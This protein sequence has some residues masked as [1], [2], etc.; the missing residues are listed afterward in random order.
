MS[1]T[2]ESTCMKP[3]EWAAL[4]CLLSLTACGIDSGN[5]T[6]PSIPNPNDIF[7]WVVQGSEA[8]VDLTDIYFIDNSLGWVVGDE[9]VLATSNGGT[10]WPLVP[11]NSPPQDLK[12]VFFIDNERGWMTGGETG[13]TKGEIFISQQGGAYPEVQ[14]SVENALN[15]VFFL[16]DAMGWAAGENGLIIHT[17]NGGTDWTPLAIDTE[18]EIFD[19][20]FSGEQWGWA[21]TDSGGVYHT[22]DGQNFDPVGLSTSSILYGVHF[23]DTLNGWVCG[24]NNSIFK[25]YLGADNQ[26]TWTSVSIPEE[27]NVTTWFDIFFLDVRN[28][29]IV[30]TEGKVYKSTDGGES[31][32]RELTNGGFD[33]LN[34]IHMTSLT[35]GWIAGNDGLILT[36]T[37]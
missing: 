32:T 13:G 29:W 16:N 35:R 10:T 21:V 30:G 1:N 2:M 23:V 4:L 26:P 24:K 22:R 20:H 34:A 18:L 36:Y 37:P 27:S 25:R 14:Q 28:G 12:S 6:N 7:D 8:T 19:I 33:Q 17:S 15:A 31:W 11:A 9:V 5:P 3:C